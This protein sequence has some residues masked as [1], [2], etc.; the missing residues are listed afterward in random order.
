MY[1]FNATC[2]AVRE[3]IVRKP[4]HPGNTGCVTMIRSG[5]VPLSKGYGGQMAI[6]PIVITRLAASR[7]MVIADPGLREDAT[8]NTLR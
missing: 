3:N 8:G 7:I 4:A 5:L 1:G 6:A 2:S